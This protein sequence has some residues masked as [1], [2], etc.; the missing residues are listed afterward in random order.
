M[1]KQNKAILLHAPNN[2]GIKPVPYPVKKTNEVLI[3][4]ESMGICGSDI[5]AY[6]GTNPLVTYPRIL[7]H[8]IVGIV[9]E[10][11][12]GMPNNIG[13]GDRVVLDPYIYCGHCYPCSIGRTN[14]CE[15]LKVIGV[16]INGGMQEIITHPAHQIVKAPDMPIE[17]LALA[18]PLTISLHALHRT[19]VKEHEHV[20]IIGAGAIGLMAALVAKTY[21]AI[22][23]LID[24]LDQ[25]LEY[26]KSIG[27]DYTI[28]SN[29]EDAQAVIK[30]V[31]KGRMAEAVIE[32]SG[33][34][35]SIQNS[36]K[37]VSFAGRIGLTGWPKT[38]T[39]LPTNIITFKELNIYG[40]RT[41]KGEFE[42]ALHLLLTEKIKAEEI[43]SKVI[44]FD[45]IPEYVQK[46]S[47]FPDE[48][49]K[50][51]AKF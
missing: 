46:L 6:R 43:I 41:S 34:N 45:E 51:V 40:S 23:I 27:I 17:K 44:E 9:L 4:V 48:Y 37:Y 22:P 5:G 30:N 13:I 33:A 35:V 12:I 20:V 32:A 3:K 28:N 16:H 2:V 19:Q 50:V 49:L 25:R 36:L 39:P 10:S 47:E 42:E 7:G 1:N 18:E 11:G 24:I 38:E 14:C 15:S 29:K 21:G 26:A 8:E 31:T